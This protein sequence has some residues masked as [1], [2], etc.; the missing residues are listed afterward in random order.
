[1]STTS[2]GGN[3]HRGGPRSF[4][5][6]AHLKATWILKLAQAKKTK[7]YYYLLQVTVRDA[8][9]KA[10][11]EELERDERVFLLGEEVAQYDGAYK[12][13]E[14]LGL[15]TFNSLSKYILLYFVF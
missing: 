8:L 1:M 11:D 7:R 3:Y 13:S 5:S 12:V 4:G 15:G 6:I 10:M 9:N 14:R 2:H